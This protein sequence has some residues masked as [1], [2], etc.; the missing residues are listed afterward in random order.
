MKLNNS[1]K[2]MDLDNWFMGLHNYLMQLYNGSMKVT[3]IIELHKT[4]KIMQ[5]YNWF[6][7]LHGC[8]MVFHNSITVYHKSV[9][10][11]PNLAFLP[12]FMCP[13]TD[14]HYGA[15]KLK[16]FIEIHKSLEGAP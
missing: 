3:W 16:G 15:A 5:L 13:Q 10:H 6:M 2:I 14:K 9:N 12:W 11:H 4:T 1:K 7:E 8:F